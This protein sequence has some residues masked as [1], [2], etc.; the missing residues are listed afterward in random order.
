[1]DR[2][3]IEVDGKLADCKWQSGLGGCCEQGCCCVDGGVVEIDFF[4][5]ADGERNDERVALGGLETNWK[6]GLRV[7]RCARSAKPVSHIDGTLSVHRSE[8]RQCVAGGQQSV[9]SPRADS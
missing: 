7:C 9:I 6:P 4:D 8:P 2:A 1:M 3:G 5:E